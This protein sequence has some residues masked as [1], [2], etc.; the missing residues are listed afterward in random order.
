M[1]KTNKRSMQMLLALG[2]IFPILIQCQEPEII[3]ET[4]LSWCEQNSSLSSLIKVNFNGNYIEYSYIPHCYS[5]DEHIDINA[6]NDTTSMGLVFSREGNGVSLLLGSKYSDTLGYEHVLACNMVGINDDICFTEN[7][8]GTITSKFSSVMRHRFT[9]WDDTITSDSINVEIEL[10]NVLQQIFYS[11]DTLYTIDSTRYYSYFH[12]W[13]YL[14]VSNGELKNFK[15]K[16]TYTHYNM[17]MFFS[18]IEWLATSGAKYAKAA[19]LGGS[20]FGLLKGSW[21][22]EGNSLI[23]N[24]HKYEK[25]VDF[26]WENNLSNYLGDR[27]QN[28]EIRIEREHNFLKLYYS[29]DSAF[30]FYAKPEE[31]NDTIIDHNKKI[32]LN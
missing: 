32:N 15:Y 6:K 5:Y 10:Y 3:E 4:E 19:Y 27:L 30:I 25:K 13:H 26:P 1:K 31:Y 9:P 23:I 21:V 22:L 28:T 2:F 24:F 7:I 8:N 12:Y 18:S 17:K 16:K 29:K 11:A 20:G 14:G